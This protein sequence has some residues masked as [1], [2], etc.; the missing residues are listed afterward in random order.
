MKILKILVSIG[1]VITFAGSV[2]ALSAFWHNY[3]TAELLHETAQAATIEEVNEIALLAMQKSSLAIA[4]QRAAWLEE[5][6][7]YYEREFSC[8][9]S[10]QTTRCTDRV[11][12]T[13][14]KYLKEYYDLQDEIRKALNK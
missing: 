8:R 5:Q 10:Q 1:V 14:Q 7:V 3:C 13:Y 4:Q 6:I 11:W 2:W 12:R 9:E